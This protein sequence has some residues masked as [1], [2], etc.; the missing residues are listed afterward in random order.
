MYILVLEKKPTNFVKNEINDLNL[1]A[2]TVAASTLSEA[3]SLLKSM[4]FDLILSDIPGTNSILTELKNHNHTPVV[5]CSDLTS[6]KNIR[7]AIKAGLLHHKLKENFL[8]N[9]DEPGLFIDLQKSKQDLQF[10]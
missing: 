10:A 6:K 4:Q 1:N 5:F 3:I 7:D 9:A 8:F 2:H